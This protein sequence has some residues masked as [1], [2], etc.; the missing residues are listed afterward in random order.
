MDFLNRNPSVIGLV[1][2]AISLF[3]LW[4]LIF[5]FE[6]YRDFVR[7]HWW[8]SVCHRPGMVFSDLQNDGDGRAFRYRD[9]IKS[10]WQVAKAQTGE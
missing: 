10:S 3:D 7:R 8:F 1:M 5:R 4:I 9:R 6:G 2:V